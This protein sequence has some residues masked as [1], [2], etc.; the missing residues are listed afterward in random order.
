LFK[1]DNVGAD[2]PV[3]DDQRLVDYCGSAAKQLLA[4]GRN[5]FDELEVF[6]GVSE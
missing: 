6:H 5:A 3:A 1:L 4:G 2:E